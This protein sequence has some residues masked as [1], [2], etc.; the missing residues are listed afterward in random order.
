MQNPSKGNKA[1]QDDKASL[2]PKPS[3]TTDGKAGVVD[4]SQNNTLGDVQ[5]GD[6]NS[7]DKADIKAQMPS[8]L[9]AIHAQEMSGENKVLAQKLSDV[10]PSDQH[11]NLVSQVLGAPIKSEKTNVDASPIIQV[12]TPGQ[13][14]C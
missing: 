5:L 13:C 2:L 7:K 3:P 11:G 14:L 6:G 9:G 12:I 8:N 10:G 4:V 1:V